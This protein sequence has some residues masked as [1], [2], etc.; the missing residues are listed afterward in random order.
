[1]LKI[2]HFK[3]K[4]IN[5]AAAEII[6]IFFKEKQESYKILIKNQNRNITNKLREEVNN[7]INKNMIIKISQKSYTINFKNNIDNLYKNNKNS[8]LSNKKTSK[9][10]LNKGLSRFHFSLYIPQKQL[11]FQNHHEYGLVYPVYI[12]DSSYNKKNSPKKIK[13]LLYSFSLFNIFFLLTGFQIIPITQLYELL[14]INDTTL[15]FS[16]LTNIFL[17]KK[18]TSYLFQY[19]SRAKNMYLLPEGTNIIIETFDNKKH[20][21]LIQDIF[22]RRVYLRYEGADKDSI[23]TNNENSFRANI[24]WGFNKENFFEGK[25]KVLDYE[26]FYQIINRINID[27]SQVKFSKSDVQLNFFTAKEKRKIV[28]RFSDRKITRKFDFNFKKMLSNYFYLKYKVY[29]KK[30]NFSRKN[31]PLLKKTKED[32]VSIISFKE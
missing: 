28:K 3:N 11:V 4:N 24:G 8:I 30:M 25:R 31:K 15:F 9:N 7:D 29:F 32:K 16:V 13:P 12:S 17:I 20:D 2:N 22:E 21:I 10:L 5:H 19:Q 1:M 6:S 14:F 23:F 26:I 18:F 27:T